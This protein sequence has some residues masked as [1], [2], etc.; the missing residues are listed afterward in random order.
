M[1]SHG[2]VEGCG[3]EECWRLISNLVEDFIFNPSISIFCYLSVVDC[4]LSRRFSYIWRVYDEKWIKAGPKKASFENVAEKA[5]KS[6]SNMSV[7]QLT[8][9]RSSKNRLNSLH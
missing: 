8:N 6:E 9:H 5:F 2:D 1:R 7:D 3:K 4:S